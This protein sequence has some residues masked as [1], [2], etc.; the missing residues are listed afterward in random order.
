MSCEFMFGYE[1]FGYE[2]RKGDGKTEKEQAW[3]PLKL[4]LKVW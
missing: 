3:R 2:E 1:G 4:F